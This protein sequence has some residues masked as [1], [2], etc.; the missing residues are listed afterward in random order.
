MPYEKDVQVR[1]SWWCPK[2]YWPFA[3]CSGIRTE[4]LWCYNF[5]WIKKTGYVFVIHNEGCENG[6]LFTWNEGGLGIGT[7]DTYAPVQEMCFDSPC[8][9]AGICDSS[10][11]GLAAS[12]LTAEQQQ[13]DWRYCRKCHSMFFDGYADKGVCPGANFKL[14]VVSTVAE[15]LNE[16]RDLVVV[17]LVGTQLHIRIFDGNGKKVV[18]KAEQELARGEALT[19]L[20]T[21][22]TSSSEDSLLVPESKQGIIRIIRDAVS[23]ADLPSPIGGHEAAGFNFVLPHDASGSEWSQRDWRYC[24]KCHTMFFDGYPDKGLCPSGGGH[25]AAGFNFVLAHDVPK[26]SAL[27]QR[28]WRYC[29]KCHTMFFDGYPGK[30]VCQA[31][32]GHAAAGFNFVLSHG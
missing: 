23:I 21:L 7:L 2:W 29:L 18:D 16:G 17:A 15:L 5:Q 4:H 10:N 1:K 26:S 31:G 19:V 20:R 30:G 24:Q 32:G 8:T 11:T 13:A 3:V 28:D 9:S 22:L 12:P 25:S 14:T 6:K 27:A